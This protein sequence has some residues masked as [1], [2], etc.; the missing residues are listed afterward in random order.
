MI[1]S[2]GVTPEIEIEVVTLSSMLSMLDGDR[3]R[4]RLSEP[5]RRG[6]GRG[7]EREGA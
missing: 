5:R 6:R 4:E 1:P 7:R 2:G 3:A